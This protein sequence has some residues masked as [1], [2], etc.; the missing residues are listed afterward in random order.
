M[1]AGGSPGDGAPDAE[2][3]LAARAKRRD[4]DPYWAFV[5]EHEA[6]IRARVRQVSEPWCLVHTGVVASREEMHEDIYAFSVQPPKNDPVPRL[7]RKLQAFRGKCSPTGF[8]C[9]VLGTLAIDWR[10]QRWGRYPWLDPTA[11]IRDAK[12]LPGA[13]QPLDRR[14]QQVFVAVILWGYTRK[15]TRELLNIS[16]EELEESIVRIEDAMTDRQLQSW[17]YRALQ[18]GIHESA[19][20]DYVE[21]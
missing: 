20:L 13:I 1:S 15:Y 2:R 6:L 9:Q 19:L 11:S 5:Q 17:R 18:G 21:D 3:P 10:R 14:T 16:D 7:K 8:L 4:E 12:R